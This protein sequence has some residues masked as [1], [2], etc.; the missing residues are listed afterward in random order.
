MK[1]KI[2]FKKLILIGSIVLITTCGFVRAL[3]ASG[4][5]GFRTFSPLIGG[6]GIWL[7]PVLGS[8]VVLH[9]LTPAL[10]VTLRIWF[11]D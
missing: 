8:V 4:H 10:A 2:L 9:W 5:A 3:I 11:V 1:K 6:L 7:T